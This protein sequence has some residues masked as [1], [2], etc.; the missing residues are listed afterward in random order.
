MLVT[1]L[2][3]IGSHSTRLFSSNCQKYLRFTGNCVTRAADGGITKWVGGSLQDY[4]AAQQRR[5]DWNQCFQDT[6]QASL[7]SLHPQWNSGFKPEREL[8]SCFGIHLLPAPKALG[9]GCKQPGCTAGEQPP[10]C[11]PSL[12]FGHLTQCRN[13]AAFI[14]TDVISDFS[15]VV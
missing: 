12:G 9:V 10:K 8:N 5:W 7:L 1:N 3:G 13:S 14:L 4:P 6:V 11:G 15:L 2:V